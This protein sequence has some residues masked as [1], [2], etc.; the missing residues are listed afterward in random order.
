[1][2]NGDSEFP[3][4]V[5]EMEIEKDA[6]SHYTRSI[7][8]K[9]RKEIKAACCHMSLDNLVTADNVKKCMIRD[10]HVKD[11]VFE[12]DLSLSSNDISCSCHLFTRVGYPCRHIFYCLSLSSIE[13]IPQQ[14]LSKCWMKNAVETYSTIDL[15]AE[16]N[17][18]S[19]EEKRK[20]TSK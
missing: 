9:V 15:V 13:Q 3:K 11:K 4:M 2:R 20:S 7:Y 10:K 12:V 18:S 19:D 5:T 6:A 8:Y 17:G 16:S 1:M 14:L